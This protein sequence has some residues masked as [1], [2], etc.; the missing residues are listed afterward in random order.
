MLYIFLGF[1]GENL[2]EETRII[3]ISNCVDDVLKQVGEMYPL[4]GEERVS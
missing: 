1:M 4:K 3:M 2:C